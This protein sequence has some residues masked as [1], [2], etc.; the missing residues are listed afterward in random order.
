MYSDH[1][2]KKTVLKAIEEYR[3][4]P[5]NSLEASL[6]Y[7]SAIAIFI[8]GILLQWSLTLRLLLCLVSTAIIFAVFKVKRNY[9]SLAMEESKYMLLEKYSNEIKALQN[10]LND[11]LDKKVEYKKIME[12]MKL[13]GKEIKVSYKA[14]NTMSVRAVAYYANVRPDKETFNNIKT[15]IRF[16][17]AKE[18]FELDIMKLVRKAQP[19][20]SKLALKYASPVE[21]ILDCIGVDWKFFKVDETQMYHPKFF[22]NS[23]VTWDSKDFSMLRN[24]L[25]EK[26]F[27]EKRAQIRE[28]TEKDK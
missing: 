11:L 25:E 16:T 17:Q 3:V 23:R 20:M 19:Y 22:I 24:V 2:T 15:C 10:T 18:S 21:I 27:E 9:I 14:M 26:D 4:E 7:I 13:I 12:D 5:L 28:L 6:I 8:V 1:K